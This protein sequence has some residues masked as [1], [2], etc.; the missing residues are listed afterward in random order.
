MAGGAEVEL[1][2]KLQRIAAEGHKITLLCCRFEG[3]QSE[4]VVEGIRIIRAGGRNNFNFV[5]PRHVKRLLKSEKFDLFVEDINKVPFYSPLYV[6]IPSIITIPHLFAKAIYHELNPILGTYIYV[7]EW[8]IFWL[9]K[10][11]QFCVV[12]ESTKIDIVSRGIPEDQVTVVHNGVNHAIY[13]NKKNYQKFEQPTVLYLGRIKKYKSVQH[14]ITAMKVVRD[15]IKDARLVVVGGGDY[16]DQLKN[17]AA[18]ENL[19]EAAQFPGFVDT[20]RK[21]EYLCRSHVMVHPSLKEGWGLTNIE[22]NCCGTAVIAADAPGLRDSVNNNHSGLLYQ[23]GNIDELAEKIILMLTDHE[24]RRRLES[25]GL[26]WAARFDWDR[27][28]REFLK[29]CQEVVSRQ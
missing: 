11:K 8:P 24:L 2:A 18:R 3:C 9:Y 25:G 17:L 6:K 15:Q 5:A 10:K 16:L 4:E 22:A 21:V 26:E 7:S 14:L 12:S 13:N 20:D 19:G 28:A 23:Y 29:L 1:E 27:S